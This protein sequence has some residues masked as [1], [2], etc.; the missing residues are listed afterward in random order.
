[1][2]HR[3]HMALP[4]AWSLAWARG[5]WSQDSLSDSPT[6][7]AP[8][9][10]PAAPSDQAP[11]QYTSPFQL[12]SVIPGNGV[13]VDSTVAPYRLDGVDG[14]VTVVLLSGQVRLVESLALQARWG[15]DDNNVSRGGGSRFG[16]LNPT[17]GVL[18]GVPIGQNFRFA[19]STVV[20]YPV[21]TG[22]GN[23][24]D[25]HDVVLQRQGMLARSAFDNTSFA[26]NDVGFPTGLSLA[27]TF[28]GLTAQV[29]ASVIPTVRV[30]GARAQRDPSK[31]NSTYGFFLAY[32]LV[33]AVSVG[34]EVRYQRYLSTPSAVRQDPSARDNLTVGGG[35]RLDLPLS[36]S[37]RVR[38][39]LCYSRGL[40]GP[41]EQQS[42]QMVQLD[43]PVSF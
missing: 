1:M 13:K 40:R 42:Y 18:F 27:Y 3:L 16:I 10:E 37:N 28:C 41:V 24:P 20:G 22:G 26:L 36:D 34:A 39:G 6:W 17:L 2:N 29:D 7:D 38:P 21:A 5:A 9:P 35:F 19:A 12:R 8:A 30:K 25:P 15:F 43:L 23:T 33:P 32:R 4:I 14:W 31:V 11:T